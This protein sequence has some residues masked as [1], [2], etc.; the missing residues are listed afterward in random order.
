MPPADVGEQNI[1]DRLRS[2]PGFGQQ[3]H[4]FVILISLQNNAAEFGLM[5]SRFAV[6]RVVTSK[7]QYSSSFR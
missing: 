1:H 4:M 2:D 3:S 6:E 5:A 7:M